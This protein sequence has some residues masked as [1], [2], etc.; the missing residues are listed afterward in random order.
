MAAAGL[1]PPTFS[2]GSRHAHHYPMMAVAGCMP[3]FFLFLRSFGV[4]IWTTL[5]QVLNSL[6][7]HRPYSAGF[8]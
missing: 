4:L 5:G 8:S 1:K 3:F 6:W 7:G 2:M